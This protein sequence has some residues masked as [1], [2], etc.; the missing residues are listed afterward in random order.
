MSSD[1]SASMKLNRKRV[2]IN[3]EVTLARA[4]DRLFDASIP[5]GIPLAGRSDRRASGASSPEIELP[6]Y[7]P[8]V[9]PSRGTGSP[10]PRP[11]LR[12]STEEG[13]SYA[14]LETSSR[15]S[16]P[17]DRVKTDE[18]TSG[19][20]KRIEPVKRKTPED[21]IITL[22]RK[23]NSHI[24][25]FYLPLEDN[26][27]DI[28]PDSNKKTGSSQKKKG[29][30]PAKK[31]TMHVQTRPKKSSMVKLNLDVVDM[32]E[33]FEPSR[34]DSPA[35][36]EGLRPEKAP[37][38][39]GRGKGLMEGL[40]AKSPRVEEARLEKDRQKEE[41]KRK[42]KDEERKK[43]VEADAKRKRADAER[44]KANSAAKKKRPA[45]EALG[46]GDRVQKMARFNTT[47]LPVEVDHLYSG[48]LDFLSLSFDDSSS[49]DTDTRFAMSAISML[50][51]Y[52]FLSDARYVLD[53]KNRKLNTHNGELVAESRMNGE[54]IASRDELSSK[55]AALTSAL[56]EAEEAK[57]D[58]VS[59][60]EGE[61][62]ELQ[63]SSKDAVARAVGVA[64]RKAKDKL[65]RSIKVMEERSR[66]Q[67]EVDRLASLASQVVGANRRMGKAA[68]EGVLIDAAKK[69]KLEARLA[70]YTAEADQIVL[71]PLPTDSSG[72]EEAEPR[73]SVA[74][75]IS[76]SDSSDEEVVGSEAEGRTSVAWK[77]PALTL[78]QI[79]EAANVEAEQVN[80]LTVELFGDQSEAEGD[81]D[82]PGSEDRIAAEE[83]AAIEEPAL[84]EGPA[85]AE[86][87]V[88][89]AAIGEPIAPLF[90]DSNPEE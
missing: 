68:K 46:S 42:L 33:E 19:G 11:M 9:G 79:E 32:D 49:S 64:K 75:D 89:D 35:K 24:C 72:D 28:L 17:S 43:K 3:Q 15:G 8:K 14:N 86:E 53:Q 13:S 23:N 4:S 82:A 12:D 21:S 59:R 48:G 16:D 34:V 81:A 52:N 38:T 66:A 45:Q 60:I 88:V 84:I 36:R 85:S 74:L 2:R 44:E 57:K 69:E 50:A 20:D 73:K 26:S 51:G 63:S 25:D 29:S 70:S 58:E 55:V 90:P 30:T 27:H 1:S 61:V 77:T 5:T 87:P 62:A 6:S 54:Q 40:L 41:A 83:T 56:G 47:S 7:R 80:R 37:I 78:A 39:H 10:V 22:L 67:T 18:G 71:P 76:S 31:K 65:R